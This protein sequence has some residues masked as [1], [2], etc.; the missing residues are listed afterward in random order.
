VISSQSLSGQQNKAMLLCE[1]AVA[2]FGF[3]PSAWSQF[4]RQNWSPSEDLAQEIH[5]EVARAIG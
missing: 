1:E 5:R 3:C 4:C 2:P